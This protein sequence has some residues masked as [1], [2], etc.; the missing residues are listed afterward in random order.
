[1]P[2][3]VGFQG[4]IDAAAA[5]ALMHSLLGALDPDAV[6]G[7]RDQR[8]NGTGIHS[9]VD[10]FAAANL[11]LGRV[12]LGIVDPQ[13]QPLWNADH[14]V[15]LVMTGEIFSWDGLRLERPL[16]GKEPDFN[17]AALLL[18]RL[19]AVRGAV[20]RPCERHVCCRHLGRNRADAALGH[21]PHRLL[22]AL[23]HAGRQPAGLWFG[24]ACG[25]AGAGAGPGSQHGGRG[26]DDCL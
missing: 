26:R 2:G 1:M 13:P 19:R 18:A 5:T 25:C 22:S 6:D 24:G 7:G 16:T 3:I 14:S 21:R 20:C 4:P 17:N 10:C 15:A 9:Y 23:L 8:S 12:H 11:G